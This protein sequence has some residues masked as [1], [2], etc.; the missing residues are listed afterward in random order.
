MDF[1]ILGPLELRKDG[2]SLACR[3]AKQRL[4][5]AALLV[6][7]NEVVSSDQL[8]EALWGEHPPPTAAKALQ[9]HVSQLRRLLDPDLLVTRPPGYELRLRDDQLDLKIFESRLA[10]AR[11][12]SAAGRTA[13]AS[14]LLVEA[15]SLWRGTPLADLTFEDF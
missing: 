4:L 9:V 15:L 3:G 13:E 6:R 10:T 11:S 12:A 14:S 7:A 1:R 5:L 2:R 8:V